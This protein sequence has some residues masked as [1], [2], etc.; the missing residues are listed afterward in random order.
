MCFVSVQCIESGLVDQIENKA[1]HAVQQIFDHIVRQH[2]QLQ[3]RQR[4]AMGE[5]KARAQLAIERLGQMQPQLQQLLTKIVRLQERIAALCQDVPSNF[6]FHQLI[7][8]VNVIL[9]RT[10]CS[11]KYDVDAQFR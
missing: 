6:S 1:S 2:T 7:E 11:V 10:N 4:T 8:E 9:E 5:L 3:V